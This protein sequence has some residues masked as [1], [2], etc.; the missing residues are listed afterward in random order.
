MTNRLLDRLAERDRTHVLAKCER[1]ELTYGEILAEPGAP[2]R[3]AYFP[4]GSFISLL[5]PMDGKYILEVALAGSEGLYGVSLAL[6]VEVSPV[7]AVVQ[8]AGPAWRIGAAGFRREL[9]RTPA[10][11]DGVDRYIHVL[12]AQLIQTS[13]CNRF[14]VVEKRVAR[15]LLMTADRT[16]ASTFHITHEF[17]AHM[18]GVRRVG[19]TEAAG[20]LQQR[21]LIGYTRGVLSILDRRGLEGAACSCYRADLNTYEAALG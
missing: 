13:G 21:K 19:I 20:A 16:H 8:G 7:Q 10:L 15:W 6:G 9:E 5:K 4:I 1:V 11:R 18:L 2:V 3:D 14:H 12:M 17:L